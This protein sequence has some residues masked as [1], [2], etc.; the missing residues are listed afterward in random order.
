M[1]ID[2]L[3][4]ESVTLA[5]FSVGGAIAIRYMARHAGHKVSKLALLGAAAPVFTKRPDF[6]YGLSKEEVNQLIEAT[7]MDRP[8][9]LAGF[10]HA[11][12]VKSSETGFT[13]WDWKRLVME[14]P[15]VQSLSHLPKRCM[16][17]S[18]DRHSSRS[19]TVVMDYSTVSWSG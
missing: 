13:D 5:G 10:S 14:Q 2:A 3:Q 1:V 11:T 9:M 12:S 16:P 15:S 18:K 4:L 19:S 8:K 6:P 17:G 7:Y